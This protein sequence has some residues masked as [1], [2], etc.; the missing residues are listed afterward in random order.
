ME[1]ERVG[2]NILSSNT[3][4]AYRVARFRIDRDTQYSPSFKGEFL[5]M[6]VKTAKEAKAICERHHA[7]NQEARIAS[8]P[9]EPAGRDA[10][11]A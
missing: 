1:W 9:K 10:A 3:I 11:P 8:E 5:T 4:P 6:P 7:I 2:A